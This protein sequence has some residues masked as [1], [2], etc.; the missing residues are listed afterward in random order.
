MTVR[1]SARSFN[2]SVF[3]N[4]DRGEAVFANS[5]S[6]SRSRCRSACVVLLG[7]ALLAAAAVPASAQ[8]RPY[9]PTVSPC[10]RAAY[11]AHHHRDCRRIFD[12]SRERRAAVA[13]TA[14]QADAMQARAVSARG[15]NAVLENPY[16]E[17]KVTMAEPAGKNAT[18]IPA[19]GF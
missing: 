11:L 12:G 15:A 4:R 7:A 1:G 8:A 2:A 14:A 18:K 5:N 9:V 13:I 10:V 19:G 16:V 17:Q 6:R 3:R